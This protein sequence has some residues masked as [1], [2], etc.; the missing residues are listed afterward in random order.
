MRC[1][2][3]GQQTGLIVLLL[4]QVPFPQQRA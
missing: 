2:M 1:T 4:E 3:Q